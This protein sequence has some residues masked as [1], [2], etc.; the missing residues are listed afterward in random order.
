MEGFVI[1]DIVLPVMLL[2]EDVLPVWTAGA[3]AIIII[4][5]VIGIWLAGEFKCRKE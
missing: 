5:D 3:A 2:G 4:L 1:I